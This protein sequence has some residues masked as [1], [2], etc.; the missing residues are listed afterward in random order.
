MG[1]NKNMIFGI[2][3]IFSAIFASICC[4]GPLIFVALGLGSIGLGS[5]LS[6]YRTIFIIITFIFL[7]I[8][9]YFVYRK[10]ETKCEDGT[11][12]VTSST[13]T[14][15]IILWIITLFVIGLV[16]FQSFGFKISSGSK[17]NVS[18]VNSS[19][20][21][22]TISNMDCAAC[23]TSIKIALEKVSGISKAEVNFETKKAEVYYE[24]GKIS[25]EDIIKIIKKIGY[26][27]NFV[28][29]E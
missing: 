11:C 23:A 7:G 3:A 26:D 29:G 24:K 18:G 12:K 2:G 25:N 28:E 13:L 6:K 27:A 10:R 16:S 9:F 17:Q 21:D 14:N 5:G 19:K 22:L 15:K 4:I 20:V 1:D 8:A